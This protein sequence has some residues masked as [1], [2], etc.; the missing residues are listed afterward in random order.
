MS[1]MCSRCGDDKTVLVTNTMLQTV[2]E[3]CNCVPFRD[4]IAELEDAALTYA[5]SVVLRRLGLEQ[6]KPKPVNDIMT[7][8]D[9]A[10][11]TPKEKT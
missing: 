8:P 7:R 5:P 10:I 9:E 2:E 11:T 6:E 4:R 3:E 1:D